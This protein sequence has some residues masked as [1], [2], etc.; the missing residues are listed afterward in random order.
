MSQKGLTM[1]K[2][3]AANRL[4]N[5]IYSIVEVSFRGAELT[6]HRH[7]KKWC[8]I[9]RFGLKAPLSKEKLLLRFQDTGL[10]IKPDKVSSDCFAVTKIYDDF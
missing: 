3:D 9:G 6:Y 10:A 8:V 5:E 7:L 2:E 1:T 4:F